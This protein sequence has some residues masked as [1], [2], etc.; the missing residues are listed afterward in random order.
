MK[1]TLSTEHISFCL[2]S[3]RTHT[4][5]AQQTLQHKPGCTT[6][7]RSKEGPSP[8]VPARA[9][10]APAKV[11]SPPDFRCREAR[12]LEMVEVHTLCFHIKSVF[13][14]KSEGNDEEQLL[15]SINIV[16]HTTHL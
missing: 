10:F 12:W 7:T 16:T 6:K 5:S 2:S 11:R 4:H 13:L 15:L 3:S 14:Y 9:A 1:E 8:P